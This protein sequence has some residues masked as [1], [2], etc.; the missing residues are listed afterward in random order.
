MKGHS[1]FQ[2]GREPKAEKDPLKTLSGREIPRRWGCKP[3]K[4]NHFHGMGITVWLWIWGYHT[5]HF[6]NC[7]QFSTKQAHA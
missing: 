1:K 4:E 7:K 5:I 6:T 2:V 3:K